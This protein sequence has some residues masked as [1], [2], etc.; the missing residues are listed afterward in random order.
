MTTKVKLTD[1]QRSILEHAA[2]HTSGRLDWFPEKLKGGARSAVLDALFKRA[3][4]TR[5]GDGWCL[6]AEAY[7]ALGCDRPT[8]ATI[9]PSHEPEAAVSA[10]EANCVQE[11]KD[12]SQHL[13]KADVEGKPRTRTN[14]KQAQ[15]I[16]LLQRSGGA[17]IPQIMEVT[18]WQSHTIRGT[19]AG[20]FKRKLGLVI[21][22]SKEAGG[23][24]T[25][26]IL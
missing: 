21:T 14:S 12:T 5:V 26:Q 23:E 9:H 24:R 11:K 6:A 18:G 19:F 16:A 20:S 8:L 1:S 7:D 3:L 22:S 10:T 15:V 2:Q 4:I 17:T 25:Y 13:L